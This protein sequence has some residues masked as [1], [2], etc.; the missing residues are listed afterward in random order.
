MGKQTSAKCQWI[1]QGARVGGSSPTTARVAF[2]NPIAQKININ[3][4]VELSLQ[5]VF[6]VARHVRNVPRNTAEDGYIFY[7]KQSGNA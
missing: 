6:H 7:D 1:A 4:P 3:A 5:R 2:S